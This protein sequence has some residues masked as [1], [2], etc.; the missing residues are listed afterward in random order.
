MARYASIDDVREKF[1]RILDKQPYALEMDGLDLVID[2]GVFPPDAA[3]STA[4]IMHALRDFQPQAALDMGCG[5]GCLAV[6]L[7]R[8]GTE[9]VYAADVY[10]PAVACARANAARNGFYDIRVVQSN[11]FSALPG[12]QRFDLIVFN[13]FYYPSDMG[14]FGPTS[15]GGASIVS[16]FFSEVAN[17][18][19][20]DGVIVMSFA[21]IGGSEHDPAHIARAHGFVVDEQVYVD[22]P[23]GVDKVIFIRQ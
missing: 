9:L 12:G 20:A 13:Q 10:A 2:K 11:L 23:L 18:L 3:T 16:R 7:R 22:D 4:M 8:L 17:W 1:Q 21:T 15:D 5:S 6:H 14:W 19:T